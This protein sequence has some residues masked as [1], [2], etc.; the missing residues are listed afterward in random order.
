MAGERHAVA[1]IDRIDERFTIDRLLSAVR[2]GHSQ[3][4]V[5]HGEAGVGKTALLRYLRERAAGCRVVR[6]VGVQSEMELAFAGLHQLC[7]PLF[8]LLDGVPGPQRDAL[9][10]AFGMSAGPP[11]DRFLVGLA[12][13]SLLST[14]AEDQ[15]LIAVVDDA[16]W[17]DKASAQ[18][19]GFVARRLGADAVGFVF[20]ARVPGEEVSGLPQMA[21][22]GLRESDARALLDSSMTGPVD[23]R[24]RE[25]FIAEA[26]GNPLALLELPRGLSA[27]EMAGGYGLLP[28]PA[29]SRRI[30]ESFRRQIGALPALTQRLLVLAAAD[31]SGDLALVWRAAGRLGIGAEAAVP[32]AEAGLAEFG[33]RL[34]FRH[35]LVRSAA[36]RSATPPER[37]QAHTALAEATDPDRD[38]DRRAWHL[39]HAAAGPDE[40]VAA[41]LERSAGRARSRGGLAASA[42]FLERAAMLTPGPGAR[43]G[44]ALAAA[45][46][47]AQAGA[48]DAALDLLAMAEA[49]PLTESQRAHADLLRARVAFYTNTGSSASALLLKAARRLELV[50]PALSRATYSEAL[51]AAGIAG[52]LAGQDADVVEVARAVAAA[53]RPPGAPRPSDLLLDGQAAHYI[54]GYAA[55]LPLLREALDAFGNGASA[56]D[57]LRWLHLA[58]NA[59]VHVWDDDRREQLSTRFLAVARGVGSLSE[60]PHALHIRGFMLLLIGDL[61]GAAALADE[62]E[63]VAEATG[64]SRPQYVRLML[65][66]LRGRDDTA[67]AMIEATVR[68][69]ARRGEGLVI[70]VAGMADAILRNGLGQYERALAAARQAT[71]FEGNQLAWNLAMPELIEAAA[72]SGERDAAAAALAALAAVTSASGTDWALGIEARC[73]ALLAVGDAAEP[74][75][76][77]AIARLGRTRLRPDLAR[78]RLLYGEWLR[79]ERRRGEAR[80]QLRTAHEMLEAMGMNAFAARARREL[81]V[82]GETARKRTEAASDRQ[83]TAQ[84]AQIARL[85]R[86][87]LSNPE[88][89]ARLFISARTVQYHL[90][91]IFAKFD[92][93][94]RAQLHLFLDEDSRE[95]LA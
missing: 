83:L 54:H 20:A 48:F 42:A 89:G 77:E 65:A 55:S 67:P 13:L 4:L 28:A 39:A 19:L 74:L 25:R 51:G 58:A 37:R 33:T 84:E 2:A 95:S 53:P 56:G 92:I 41:E 10:T 85:A 3:V 81:Q 18:A 14:A 61:P 94:S 16:Q 57:E 40:D 50:D 31:S 17:L 44:R 88:I 66:G 91:K 26:R 79:R 38:P 46:V 78:A 32:A 60:L 30:E 24:V 93:T 9:R 90:G 45:G 63:A 82:T 72:R 71:S 12:A 49:G 70:A 22:E 11:P 68:E 59:A 35:P 43:A 73:R 27:A 64:A 87:G 76:Q 1:L 52:R 69:A 29:L 6:A 5:M 62:L 34:R 7:T 75:Y 21:I 23:D 47:K 86:D 8:D 15:P 80:D 36:Y